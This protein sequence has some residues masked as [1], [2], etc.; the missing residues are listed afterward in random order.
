MNRPQAIQ[1]VVA[2]LHGDELLVA[3]NGAIS[4]EL[5]ACSDRP[6]NF[7]LLGAMGLP[8]A[9]GLGLAM[10]RPERKILILDGD[11]NLLMGFGNLI[12]IG[13]VKPSNL[14]H[15]VL[16]NGCYATTGEQPSLAPQVDICQA[17]LACGYAHAL[18]LKRKEDLKMALEQMANWPGPHLLRI[19]I[20]RRAAPPAVP[21]PR[22]PYP[23]VE[24]KKRFL[25][26]V[27]G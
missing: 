14:S 2:S 10:H 9:V 12:Q 26:A 23:A 18:E 5:Y 1:T 8:G 3:A 6:G 15:L 19:R 13:A 25:Q 21:A 20:D 24:I 4:R 17:A 27:N 16:D 7:Y 22:I 11:G